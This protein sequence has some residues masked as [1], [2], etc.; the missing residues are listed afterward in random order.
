[1]HKDNRT[2]LVRT[3]MLIESMDG[4]YED[5]NMGHV[6]WLKEQLL[7]DLIAKYPD[8]KDLY[9]HIIQ[10]HDRAKKAEEVRHRGYVLDFNRTHRKEWKAAMLNAQR[11]IFH[12]P[13]EHKRKII[14]T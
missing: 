2:G 12:I 7:W 9:H 4:E 8:P 3:A 1:M 10:E 14:I 5:L 6:R 11:G 13:E